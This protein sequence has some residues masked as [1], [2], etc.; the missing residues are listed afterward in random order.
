MKKIVVMCDPPS[1]WKYGFPKAL[2]EHC[3]DNY[4]AKIEWMISEGYPEK[5]IK[6]FGDHFHVRYWQEEVEA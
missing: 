1:G 6:E 2:P 3:I 5:T 4:K